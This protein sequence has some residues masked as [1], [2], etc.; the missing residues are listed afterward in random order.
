M[1]CENRNGEV[2]MKIMI[3]EDDSTIRD[4]VNESL[5]KWGFQTITVDNFDQIL[6][7]FLS[8][9]PQ[10]I[11][12]DINLPAYDGFYWCNQI[13]EVSKVPIIFLSSRNTPLDMVMAMNMGGDDYIQKPFHMDVLIAKVSALLRRTYSYTAID[14][15]VM[16]HDGVIL[17]MQDGSLSYE[18]QKVQLTKTEFSIMKILMQNQGTIVDRKK[19]MRSLWKDERFVDDNTLT[20]NIVRLRKKLNELGKKNF[21]LTKKGQGYFID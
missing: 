20:V 21:I 10:L 8:S 18:D 7:Q 19:I 12:M 14:W 5:K 17:D 16:E 4:L 15:A 9:K 2:P 3:V 1:S 13:R 6:Q 11:L